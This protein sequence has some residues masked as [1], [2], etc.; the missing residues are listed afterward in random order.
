MKKAFLLMMT[1]CVIISSMAFSAYAEEPTDETEFTIDISD[2]LPMNGFGYVK[3]QVD[4]TPKGFSGMVMVELEDSDGE[5]IEEGIRYQDHWS[6][7][8][9]IKE[10][11]CKILRVYVYESDQYLASCEVDHID[12]DHNEDQ[13]LS[14]QVIKN[15]DAPELI[16][17]WTSSKPDAESTDETVQ[18]SVPTDATAASTTTS[19][20]TDPAEIPTDSTMHFPWALLLGTG[21][22][23]AVLFFC[24][25]G[26]KKKNK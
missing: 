3:I 25:R 16:P 20:S 24:I 1:I 2:L 23:V 14:V 19:E 26:A 11:S 17:S 15:P 9:Y 7:G 6:K 18:T 4:S 8:I 10:G 22:A 12:V 5:K 13:V 21:A